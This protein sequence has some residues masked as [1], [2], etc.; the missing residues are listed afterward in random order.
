MTRTQIFSII[1]ITYP[2]NSYYQVVCRPVK[3]QRVTSKFVSKQ[4]KIITVFQSINE[5]SM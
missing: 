4:E 5:Q 3:L 1:L 2:I